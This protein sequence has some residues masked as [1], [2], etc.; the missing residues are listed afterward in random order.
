MGGAENALMRGVKIGEDVMGRDEKAAKYAEYEAQLA[1]LDKDL[2]DPEAE[3][4]Q[5]LQAFLIGTAGASNIGYA[6]AGGAAA[7]INLENQQKRNQRSRMLSRIQLGERGM[8]LDSEM[9]KAALNIGNQMFADFN[10]NKRTAI[11]AG[12]TLE[13]AR[14]RKV[15]ADADREFEREKQ[16]DNKVLKTR[17]LDIREAETAV[18]Q[19]RNEE[20]SLSRRTEGVLK[21]TNNLLQ[22][23]EDVYKMAADRYDLEGAAADLSMLNPDDEGYVAARAKFETVSAEADAWATQY[24]ENLGIN[25]R[26]QELE[27]EYYKLTGVD[28]M[29]GLNPDDIVDVQPQG[30]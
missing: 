24:L 11:S 23:S 28:N 29:P 19:A 14:L 4:R 6:M 5:Q 16:D 27:R 3:R 7:A 25:D 15:T 8:T 22:R 12:A 10:A 13:A 30:E 21:A 2:Y 9:G 17:E 20:L 1:E 26:L 18:Q